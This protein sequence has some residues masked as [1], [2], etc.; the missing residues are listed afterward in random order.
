MLVIDD[1]LPLRQVLRSI[2]ERAGYTVLGAPDGH[3]KMALRRE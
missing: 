3:K 2:P 1:E